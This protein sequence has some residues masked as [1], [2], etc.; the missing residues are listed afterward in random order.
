MIGACEK[1]GR[2]AEGELYTFYYGTESKQHQRAGAMGDHTITTTTRQ[3][4][5]SKSA[6][7]CARCVARSAR[8]TA[9][10]SLIL[11]VILAALAFG[12]PFLPASARVW[13]SAFSFL[14]V[15]VCF[16]PAALLLV[17][18][19]VFL[20]KGKSRDVGETVAVEVHKNE[21]SAKTGAN[22]F[23]TTGEYAG[24]QK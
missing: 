9:L 4:M 12:V 7:I 11:S 5:G 10:V 1:C 17:V 6:F 16:A 20:F 13:E 19:I 14:P 24:S 3:V 8:N 22:K 23:W 21:I 15:V 18:G 2:E